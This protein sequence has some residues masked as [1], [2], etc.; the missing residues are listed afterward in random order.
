LEDQILEKQ[1]IDF[2]KHGLEEEIAIYKAILDFSKNENRLLEKGAPLASVFANINKKMEMVEKASTLDD[3]LKDLKHEWVE[4][5]HKG[6]DLPQEIVSLLR[7]VENVLQETILL[8]EQNNKK[9]MNLY[10]DGNI[11][12]KPLDIE[13]NRV[14]RAKHAYGNF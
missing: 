4:Q 7:E 13:Q 11:A 1:Q 5:Q 12:S 14:L 10:R 2:L 3:S 6:E 9:I 8:D